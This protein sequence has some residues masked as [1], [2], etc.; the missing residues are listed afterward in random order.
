MAGQSVV[1]S[2]LADGKPFNKTIDDISKK[3]S[4]LGKVLGG[5]GKVAAAGLAVGAL[6][7]GGFLGSSFKAVAEVE[8][9]GA[10]TA[11]VIESTGGAAQRSIGQVTGLAESLEKLTGIEMETISAGQNVLLTFTQIKGTNFD[12]ATE[13]ALN[14]SV[15]LGTDMTSA[16]TL[17]GKALNDPIKGMGALSKA[18]VQ[19]TDDQKKLITSLVETGD[20]AG[21]QA[22]ILGELNTQFGGSAEAFGGTFLGTVEKVKNSFGDLGESIVTSFLPVA[23]TALNKLNDTLI[24]IGDSPA[25]QAML[26][27]VSGFIESLFNGEQDSGF[28]GMLGDI[29]GAL[30]P[31]GLIIE[32]VTPLLPDLKNAFADLGTAVVESGLYDAL[33]DLGEELGGA[34]A[35]AA[36]E[37]AP[38]I[39]ELVTAIAELLPAIVPLIPQLFDLAEPVIELIGPLAEFVGILFGSTDKESNIEETVG[40]ISTALG[41]L[42]GIL[43]YASG[44]WTGLLDILGTFMKF[45]SGEFSFDD[46]QEHFLNADNWMGNMIRGAQNLGQGIRNFVNDAITNIRNFGSNVGTK[47]GEV[48]GFFTSL[49]GR[50][51]G[52][53]SGAGSWLVDAGKNIVQGLINGVGS[54]ADKAVKAVTG[55]GGRMVDGVKSFLGIKSP[56]RVFQ[57]LGNY[58]VEGLAWGL[59][60]TEPVTRAVKGLAGSLVDSWAPG[61][62]GVPVS[63]ADGPRPGSSAYGNHYTVNV[64]MLNPSAES[65]RVI[66]ESIEDYERMNGKPKP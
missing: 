63:L 43:D 40:G 3:T 22:I 49:P 55:I 16:A 38:V 31:L 23:T 50:I 39:V 57:K 60:K 4:G 6:A 46:M 53:L 47:L 17:V 61:T 45:V 58:V 32:A 7:L 37:L 9:L 26:D 1:V 51:T 19:L 48:A 33:I 42:G 56:S 30:S 25:W 65:G 29:V 24:A 18:G 12:K 28:V 13:A 27:N 5:M 36:I 54:L 2:V 11:A 41:V 10:Q 15:A 8:R 21:A 52:A 62:L 34:L 64:S 44:L 66:V 20:V 35:D 14:M 59:E